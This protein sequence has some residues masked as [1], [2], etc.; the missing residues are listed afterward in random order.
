MVRT[1]KPMVVVTRTRFK[2]AA[3]HRNDGFSTTCT[4]TLGDRP[5]HKD[6]SPDDT[7][8]E[9]DARVDA[10]QPLADPTPA[11]QEPAPM[12]FPRSTALPTAAETSAPAPHRP[13]LASLLQHLAPLRVIPHLANPSTPT[14]CSMSDFMQR[15]CPPD[16]VQGLWARF[17]DST[18]AAM[19]SSQAQARALAWHGTR[20]EAAF[21]TRLVRTAPVPVANDQ[22]VLCRV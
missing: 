2:Q 19:C 13:S 14:C 22:T 5:T 8:Y 10:T 15:H 7:G 16:V 21:L 3:A 12:D 1:K 11:H 4:V 18:I 20:M 9:Q 17:Q 6:P